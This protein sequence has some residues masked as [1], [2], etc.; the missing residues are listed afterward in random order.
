MLRL[1]KKIVICGICGLIV[2]ALAI[3]L[4]IYFGLERN[5]ET[6]ERYEDTWRQRQAGVVSNGFECASIGGS[7]LNKNGTAVDAAIATMICEGVATPQSTGL[8]GGFLMVIYI[9]ESRTI[10]TL[11]AR[12]MA[13]LAAT[14]DMYGGDSSIS[15]K[16]GLSIAVPGE[17]RGL[18]YAHQRFGHLSWADLM[19]PT[20]ELC[21]QGHVVTP[22]IESVFIKNEAQIRKDP[23]LRKTF[24]NPATNQVYK[25]GDLIK[26]LKLAKTLEIIAKDGADALY[27]GVL[28]KAFIKDIQSVG[29]IITEEDLKAYKPVWGNPVVAHLPEDLTL[30][31]IPL[32]G[33]GLIVTFIM[34]V[35]QT[36]LD[37]TK[38]NKTVNWQ[39]IIE[40]FKYAYA[41]RTDLGD[42]SFVE[43]IE[44]V[45]ANLTS[46]PYALNVRSKI[47]DNI[48]FEDP[49]H[50][51]ANFSLHNDQGT[52]HI[53]VLA[54]NGDAVAVTGTINQVFGSGFASGSTGIILNDEMDD[55]SSPNIT[56]GFGLPPSPA[57][58]IRPKKRPLSSMC[59]TIITDKEGEVVLVIGAAGGSKITTSVALATLR[60]LW[61][62]ESLSYAINSSRVHHQLMPM[63][64]DYETNFTASIIQE[65]QQIGHKVKMIP[66]TDGFA[67]ITG[68]SNRNGVVEGSVDP[69]RGGAVYIIK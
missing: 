58:F 44:E 21:K 67:A 33:S 64:I 27:N 42:P 41:K 14:E 45:I 46:F 65:L 39:R 29:G 8:G 62:N 1:S 54:K 61:F 69:R 20:I 11:N 32:P 68:V 36:F 63:R 28:T 66:P 30:H 9:R 13:P 6:I 22:Y 12:E 50:Y 53:S 51:G 15:F 18:W 49:K 23:E 10:V 35:L 26:R 57:N 7:I 55:F 16:G 40:T 38:L 34:N 4:G 37:T 17:L 2:A 60:H 25:K 19:Q 48:T 31:S 47:T 3:S 5:T 59:P 24:I 52:A 43:G 56:N